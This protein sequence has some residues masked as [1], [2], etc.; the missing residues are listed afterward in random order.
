MQIKALFTRNLADGMVTRSETHL[1]ER[2]GLEIRSID[3]TQT[4]PCQLL[5]KLSIGTAVFVRNELLIA[6]FSIFVDR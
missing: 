4:R 5:G 3:L 1:V 2:H 6:D